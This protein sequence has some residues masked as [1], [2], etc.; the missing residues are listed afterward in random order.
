MFLGNS[1][2]IRG[3]LGTVD[4]RACCNMVLMEY[5]PVLDNWISASSPILTRSLLVTGKRKS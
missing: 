3:S 4:M 5:S 2:S 1:V